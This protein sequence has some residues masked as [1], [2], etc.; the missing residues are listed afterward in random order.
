MAYSNMSQL[1]MLAYDSGRA[2]DWGHRARS[3]PG[4]SATWRPRR[5]P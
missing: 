3:W 5:T 2:I 1:L 4:G